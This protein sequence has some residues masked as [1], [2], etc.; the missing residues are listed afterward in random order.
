MIYAMP[1]FTNE[2]SNASQL[3]TQYSIRHRKLAGVKIFKLHPP[4]K[5]QR[6]LV[7]CLYYRYVSQ[8]DAGKLKNFLE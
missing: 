3:D 4:C 2:Q 5:L 6:P 1:L 7:I 8:A